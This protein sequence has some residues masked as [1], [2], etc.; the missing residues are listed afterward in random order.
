MAPQSSGVK[1][2]DF[3]DVF[4]RQF[5]A[6]MFFPARLIAA[7]SGFTFFVV[8]PLSAEMDMP[9][10]TTSGS[11]AIVEHFKSSGDWSVIELPRNTV[12][13]FTSTTIEKVPVPVLIQRSIPQPTTIVNQNARLETF[14]QSFARR[15]DESLEESVA[16]ISASTSEVARGVVAAFGVE[17]KV[18][19]A[20]T[21]HIVAGVADTQPLRG[22][23]E[24]EPEPTRSVNRIAVLSEHG[25]PS[26][27]GAS[28]PNLTRS[29]CGVVDW[30]RTVRINVLVEP[31]DWVHELSRHNSISVVFSGAQSM[32]S[33]LSAATLA[34]IGS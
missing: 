12:S 26:V 28:G 21:Q 2:A 3:Q 22:A 24:I 33:R 16:T 20:N 17:V 32:S 5:S 15:F 1:T 14:T 23:F 30:H 27:I 18:A 11:V 25:T 13:A 29:Q 6:A 31:K 9:R 19:Q 7:T 34:N 4:R 8:F 10:I